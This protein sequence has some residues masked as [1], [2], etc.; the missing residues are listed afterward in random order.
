MGNILYHY[1][2]TGALKGIIRKDHICLWATRY[3]HLN[4]PNE[5]LWAKSIIKPYLIKNCEI[6]EEEFNN[7]YNVF[8]YIL[9]F[10]K[11]MDDMT[12]WRLYCND[13]RGIMLCFDYDSIFN[14]SEKHKKAKMDDD[15]DMLLP[16]VYTKRDEANIK[17]AF[18]KAKENHD[19]WYET[20]NDPSE[21][22]MEIFAFVKN[23][24]YKVEQEIRYVR[25]KTSLIYFSPLGKNDCNEES[26][27]DSLGVKIRNRGDELI[28]FIELSFPI[29]SLKRVV[30]G[31]NLDFHNTEETIKIL[32]NNLNEEYNKVEIVKSNYCYI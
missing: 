2:S 1:T 28:P 30:I 4:D 23:D 31:Y 3:N 22:N 12:M 24:G 32:F 16:V 11:E 21:N 7:T 6:S 14:E 26:K 25:K 29:A 20:V 5:N 13:G 10:C 18:M 9:S 17:D 8:P 27:E 19:K 15:W